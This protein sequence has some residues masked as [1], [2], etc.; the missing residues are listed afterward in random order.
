MSCLNEA[1]LLRAGDLIKR[2]DELLVEH[3]DAKIQLAVIESELKQVERERQA[4][5][6][7]TFG[8]VLG[9]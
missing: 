6:Q 4:Q 9:K 7:A 8:G 5:L 1:A 2:R 3:M